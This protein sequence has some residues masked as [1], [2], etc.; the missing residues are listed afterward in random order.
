[1][2]D[3][4]IPSDYGYVVTVAILSVIQ[5]S[6]MG[7]SVGRYRRQA[8]VPYPFEYAEKAEAD[9]DFNKHIFNCKQRVH[10]NTLEGFPAFA[11]LL[12][13][14]GLEHPITTAA[15]GAFYLLGRQI[16]SAGY[17]TGNP[18]KREYGM[19]GVL[20]TLV[21]LGTSVCTAY[22]LLS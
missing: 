7:I 2:V 3:I 12:F 10:Q 16:Y 11:V 6:A 15:A 18:A 1:M 19:V 5:L 22:S 9:A 20:G 14:G 8:G 13:V 17:S 4:T 21:M